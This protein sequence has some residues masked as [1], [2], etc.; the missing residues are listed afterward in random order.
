MKAVIVHPGKE[1]AILSDVRERGEVRDGQVRLRTVRVG[2]CGTDRGIVTGKITFARPP[3]GFDYL[4]LGHEGLAR[5]EEL[6]EEKSSLKE[7][8]LVVPVVR[9]GCGKC[10]N[11]KI[12][13]QDFCETGEFV[14][15]G[16]RGMHGFMR[17]EFVDEEKYL[18]K[19]PAELG[20]LG[21]LAEPLSNVVKA[22]DELIFVQKRSV[23]HCDDSS[24]G[25]RNVTVIGSGPIGQFFA[26]IF[27]VNHFNVTVV[28]R[29]EP[30][31]T[32]EKIAKTVGYSFLNTSKG[33]DD[34][35]ESDVIV[36]TSGYPS[37]FI[38]LLKKMKRNGALVLFGTVGGE[39]YEIDSSLITSLVEDNIAVIAS[40][41]ASK[42]DF[43]QGMEY[44]S[45]WKHRYGDVLSSM[46]TRVVKP[47][48]ASDAILEKTKGSI[49]TVVEWGR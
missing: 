38:P 42:L 41:N 45:L 24:Y 17:E 33:I 29:R 20:E 25:C 8:D 32:E 30:N 9:R 1:G 2:V 23:W 12:G 11:C 3:T 4:V 35:P 39:K 22:Y 26:M 47:E 36:D 44:L 15:A 14:E 18:V 31:P 48:E 46:I 5:V 19:V 7:G 28:N 21:V 40:V 37:A 10:L 6:G 13:R 34:V 49:K 16:I 27:K 43:Q